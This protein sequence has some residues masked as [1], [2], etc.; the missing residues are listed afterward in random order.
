MMTKTTGLTMEEC[1][2]NR[3]LVEVINEVTLTI[4]KMF[5]AGTYTLHSS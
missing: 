1:S 4:N 5:L 2:Q 3:H